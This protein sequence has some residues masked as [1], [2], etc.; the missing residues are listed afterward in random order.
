M[1]ALSLLAVVLVLAFPSAAPAGTCE[2]EAELLARSYGLASAGSAA[3]PEERSN[4]PTL[5][6]PPS[7]ESRS[8]AEA[9]GS[10]QTPALEPER[11]GRMEAALAAARAAGDEQQC[12]QLLEQARSAAPG[13]ATGR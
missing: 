4:Q 5:E 11:R 7:P 10:S 9:A 3:P 6:A 1:R 8:P 2:E 13:K 12:F